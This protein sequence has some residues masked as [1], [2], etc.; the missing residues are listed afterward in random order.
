MD[1]LNI[2]QW[3]KNAK[4]SEKKPIF[5]IG[6]CVLEN[7]DI[8]IKVANVIK[9]IEQKYAANIVFKASFDKANRTDINSERGPGIEK[10]IQQLNNIKITFDLPIITDI[11]LPQQADIVSEYVDIIQIPAFLSRQTDILVAAAK[12]RLPVNIKKGQF[13]SPKEA[14]EAIKKVKQNNNNNIF[15]TERGTFFGYHDL[16][17]DFRSV[18]VL[19]DEALVIYDITHSQ[20]KPAL[21]GSSSGGG[22]RFEPWLARAAFGSGVDGYFIETHPDPKNAI[23]DKHTQFPLQYLQFLVEDLIKLHNFS[24]Q[25]HDWT[26]FN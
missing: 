26:E 10:G 9:E 16:I 21:Y 6:P 19:Q 8:N 11:H 18:K 3:I 7:D 4:T 13:L 24:S 20:Q 17:N 1:K 15:I 25:L 2:I 5:F 22:R 12:T 23:S 14:I